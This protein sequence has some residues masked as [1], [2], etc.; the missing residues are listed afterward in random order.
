MLEQFVNQ[1]KRNH[2]S[3]QEVRVA[4]EAFALTSAAEEKAQAAFP[5]DATSST[6]EP[7][8]EVSETSASADAPA[9]E[10]AAAPEAAPIAP[11][12]ASKEEESTTVEQSSI[13][14]I[15]VLIRKYHLK[16]VNSILNEIA[17]WNE[18]NSTTL[19]P[20]VLTPRE[21][22][23][24]Q[25]YSVTDTELTPGQIIDSYKQKEGYPATARRHVLAALEEI[26][27][28][29]RNLE[30]D[31]PTAGHHAWSNAQII[32][33]LLERLTRWGAALYNQD[34]TNPKDMWGFLLKQFSTHRYL[35]KPVATHFPFRLEAFQERHMVLAPLVTQTYGSNDL[36]VE[37]LT[38]PLLTM[39]R[40]LR[41]Q[42][43]RRLTLDE[44]RKQ[45][46]KRRL[47][48]TSISAA[49]LAIA[50]VTV[51]WFL[52]P[53]TLS[54]VALPK[55]SLTG[56]I[57]GNYYGGQNFNRF[58]SRRVDRGI[59]MYWHNRPMKKV[60]ADFYSVRW[61][62]YLEAPVGGKFRLCAEFDDGV[63]FRLGTKDVVKEWHVG[64]ARSKCKVIFL[65][66]GWHPL[67]LQMFEARG[68]AVVKLSWEHAKRKGLHPIPAKHFCCKK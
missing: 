8:A 51:W 47:L 44:E 28:L 50:A 21:T 68:L 49:T 38:Q 23:L 45:R 17:A 12:E 13:T 6:T 57:I 15:V 25:R 9:E 2:P 31:F 16:T 33:S 5:A 46:T 41:R 55:G 26:Q 40:E 3:I 20:V 43:H 52:R 22:E 42:A 29:L 54:A 7:A 34:Y 14:S 4:G 39:A 58:I 53:P 19:R 60:P 32:E 48:V 65:E 36:E 10:N 27:R 64:G 63:Q 18:L 66:K 30:Q 24:L 59:N 62:G 37:Q 35:S 1:L 56:G 67:H 11:A 61:K